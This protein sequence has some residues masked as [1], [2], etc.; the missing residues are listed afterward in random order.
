MEAEMHKA[1]NYTDELAKAYKKAAKSLK[2]DVNSW[3]ARFAKNNQISL[4]K[5]KK[6]LRKGE[7]E[8]FRWTLEEY[9]DKAKSNGSGKWTK[10]L[11]NASARVHVTRLQALELQCYQHAY[12]ATG[13]LYDGLHALAKE[14]YTD[15]FYRT[16]YDYQRGIG[17]YSPFA[18]INP[19]V[20]E[21][22]ILKPWAADGSN[23]S[24]RIWKNRDA[25]MQELHTGLTQ[26]LI[27]GDSLDSLSEHLAN[28]FNVSLNRARTL[29]LSESA[30]FT[31]AAQ[32]DSMIA[33]GVKK[34]DIVSTLDMKT[35]SEC[36]SMDGKTFLMAE[37]EPGVTA[38]VFHARCR[39]CIAPHIEGYADETRV[40]RDTNTGKSIEIKDMNYPRWKNEFLY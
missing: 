28:R 21:K 33:L 35:C 11:E 15:G 9:M 32:K 38:P 19:D 40:A 25:L 30:F 16:G 27:R 31:G 1:D 12:E 3:Y 22:V 4:R 36:G 8:E 20:V 39:C 2:D 34:Y 10:M 14:I 37:W 13:S 24:A 5:A 6:L 7:L 18:K 26:A 23:F 17:K 29:V